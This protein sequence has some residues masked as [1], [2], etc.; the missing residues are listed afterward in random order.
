MR[1]TALLVTLAA[2]AASLTPDS[3]VPA[4]AANPTRRPVVLMHGLM[5]TSSAMSHAQGWI[6]EDFPGIYVKNVEVTNSKIQSLLVDIN[7]QV[8]R[9]AAQV[10]GDPALARGFNLIGHSQGGLIGRAYIH[11][12]NDPP[13]YNFVSWVGP[14]AGVYGVPDFNALCPDVVC[15][16]LNELFDLLM[17]PDG[18]ARVEQDLLTFAAYWRSPLNY[19]SYLRH[20]EFLAD[21]NNERETKNA[22]Y[23]L[24]F[25]SLNHLALLWSEKVGGVGG[26]AHIGGAGGMYCW[27]W[28]C[29]SCWWWC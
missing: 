13:V 15:P 26:G 21:I 14:M 10:R 17:Q 24:N 4:V 6:E 22:T 7:V 8:E 2:A 9:F 5:A 23:K 3:D 12:F 16:W 25:E 20:N 28:R 27:C 19:S 11:R 29:W 18:A 1:P